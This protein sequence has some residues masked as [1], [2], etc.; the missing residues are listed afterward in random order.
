MVAID[1]LL[2]ATDQINI[3]GTVDTYPNWRHKLP[4]PIDQWT[5]QPT[6]RATVEAFDNA[7]RAQR[8]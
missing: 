6:F 3:P 8:R 4:L 1:D 7:C 2:E 5:E